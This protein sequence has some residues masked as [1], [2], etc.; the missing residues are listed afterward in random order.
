MP[1]A[2]LKRME[3]ETLEGRWVRLQHFDGT[4]RE[5]WVVD[6][7]VAWPEGRLIVSRTDPD[8]V[9]THANQTFV[10]MSGYDRDELM[11]STHTVLR[12]PDM[13]KE[14]FA[15]MWNTLLQGKNWLGYL[16]NL[17]K[18]GRYYWVKATVMPNIREGEL[19]GY[20]SVRKRPSRDKVRE[21]EALYQQYRDVAAS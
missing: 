1:V 7:E 5:V 18:D 13:P 2:E 14:V 3:T 6:Q 17:C 16:K 20:T 9:I 21:Y 11:G 8:G 19:K 10:E 4:Q 15:E 12:H